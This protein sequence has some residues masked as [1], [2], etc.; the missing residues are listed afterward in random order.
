MSQSPHQNHQSTQPKKGGILSQF[1]EFFGM[2]PSV[3]SE[4]L[5]SHEPSQKK[6]VQKLWRCKSCQNPV[7]WRAKEERWQ[8]KDH[9]QA[10][11]V[12]YL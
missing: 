8:C 9:P 6:E 5:T 1:L 11:V 12:D 2:T 7:Q 4:Y 10:E 3:P